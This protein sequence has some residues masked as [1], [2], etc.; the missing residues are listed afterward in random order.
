MS[1][2][3][4]HPF[5]DSTIGTSILD[6]EPTVGLNVHTPAT[7]REAEERIEGRRGVK[8]SNSLIEVQRAGNGASVPLLVKVAK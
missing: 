7:L 8:H 6:R 1:R 4:S 3:A 2:P 5:R